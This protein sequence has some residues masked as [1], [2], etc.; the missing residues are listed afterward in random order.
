MFDYISVTPPY[1]EVDYEVLMDQI[2]KSP[3]IGENT[4]I[5]SSYIFPFLNHLIRILGQ[6][7]ILVLFWTKSDLVGRV[8]ITNNNA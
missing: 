6:C 4:F 2:A 3:A 7:V 1:M 8:P 5:V